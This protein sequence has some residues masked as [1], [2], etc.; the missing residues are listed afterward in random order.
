M[1]DPAFERLLGGVDPLA[2]FTK[3]RS[4]DLVPSATKALGFIGMDDRE[5]GS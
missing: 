1:V 5:E 3:A 2:C 4:T